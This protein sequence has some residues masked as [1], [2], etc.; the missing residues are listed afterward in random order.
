MPVAPSAPRPARA[1]L[2]AAVD[3]TFARWDA[4]ASGLTFTGTVRAAATGSP[5]CGPYTSARART[6][7]LA[8]RQTKTHN[9][10]SAVTGTTRAKVRYALATRDAPGR[11]W[12]RLNT[13]AVVALYAPEM[14]AS[15]GRTLTRAARAGS[16]SHD[17]YIQFTT[18]RLPPHLRSAME[19]PCAAALMVP[20]KHVAETA[21]GDIETE[22]LGGVTTYTLRSQALDFTLDGTPLTRATLE[23]VVGADGLLSAYTVTVAGRLLAS[24]HITATARLRTHAAHVAA[25]S[26]PFPP[27]FTPLPLPAP[28]PPGVAERK[29][30]STATT[31][32]KMLQA[33]SAFTQVALTDAAYVV[34]AYVIAGFPVEAI[35]SGLPDGT[36][37]TAVV[38][39]RSFGHTCTVHLSPQAGGANTVSC[40]L[41]PQ[42][43]PPANSPGTRGAEP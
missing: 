23:Y 33:D 40:V 12:T 1:T 30:V 36:Q 15:Q 31:V 10:R 43:P 5:S 20:T 34:P 38:I 17:P 11:A 19:P 14:T 25:T 41:E 42:I 39:V 16:G 24:S 6:F 27:D 18:D 8:S 4:G 22:R 28:L 37:P 9:W 7:R 32:A 26:L 2:Q 21:P 3:A 35:V 13:A 29:A